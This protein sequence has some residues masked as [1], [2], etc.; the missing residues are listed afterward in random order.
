LGHL[1]ARLDGPE[2]EQ[3][4]LRAAA[5]VSLYQRA[6]QLPEAR[7]EP[8]PPPCERDEQPRCSPHAGQ[9]LALMLQ[10]QYQ[11]VLPEWLAAVARAG[12]R[13]P[14]NLLPD[15]LDLGRAQSDLRD[16]IGPVLGQR[17]RW[18]AAQNPDWDY[19]ATGDGDDETLWQ[20]GRRAARRALLQRLRGQD[21]AR[22]RE[23]L[24]ATWAEETPEDRAAFLSTLQTGLSRADEPFLEEA[25]DDRRKEVRR[26]AADLLARLP[27]SGLSQRMLE[28]VRPLLTLT[29]GR[30]PRVEVAL[31]EA[32]DKAM[33][34]D[35]IEPKPPSRQGEKAWWLQQML[36]AIPPATWSQASGQ[37]PAEWI[38]AAGRGEWRAL[39]LQGWADAAQR[40]GD[41]DWIEALLTELLK[42]REA[43]DLPALFR[44]LP[45]SRQEAF[46]LTVLRSNPSLQPDQPA[47]GFLPSCQHP[48]SEEL[49]RAVLQSLVRHAAKKDFK[50]P[51]VWPSFLKDLA[52]YLSP[53]LVSEA[54]SHLSEAA[55]AEA[56]W[57]GAIEEFL[58]RLQFRYDMLKEI[59]P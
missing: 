3:V 58:A 40:H 45:P 1:L 30:K 56:P 16:A 4:L 14:E 35:G 21:P 13:V 2:R 47:H 22:A 37:K 12:Q 5:A 49:S 24:A 18:L 33:I 42:Q 44:A 25:L 6:G 36:G 55:R 46:V 39:L 27:E 52:C 28:R 9:R 10:G 48:W 32:C 29:A 51:W 34:R 43:V 41:A 8:L 19:G 50:N 20:T 26:T 57:S 31:P 53:A 59:N 7:G 54:V 15:L 11:E 17:G 38:Q 23:L